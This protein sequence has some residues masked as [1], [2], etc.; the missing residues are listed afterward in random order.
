ME[1]HR[2]FSRMGGGEKNPSNLTACFSRLTNQIVFKRLA[3]VRTWLGSV[4]NGTMLQFSAI[5]LKE[6]GRCCFNILERLKT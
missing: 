5:Q 2:I 6:K 1:V 4:Q 3:T